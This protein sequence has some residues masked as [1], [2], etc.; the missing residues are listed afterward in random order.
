MYR[1]LAWEL[2]RTILRLS[3]DDIPVDILEK[4]GA[5]LNKKNR[6]RLEQI[7]GLA[8]EVLDSAEPV[9]SPKPE[10]EKGLSAEEVKEIVQ[11]S[12]SYIIAKAQGKLN[13]TAR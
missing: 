12:V 8:Q 13:I 7:Q 9:E 5:V 4:I 6:E 10:D 11:Q 1:A 2:V 3:G